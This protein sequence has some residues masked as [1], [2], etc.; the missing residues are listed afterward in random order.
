MDIDMALNKNDEKIIRAI[1]KEE[2]EPTK[3]CVQTLHQT[4]YGS[5]EKGGMKAVVARHDKDLDSLKTFRTQI[6]T[7]LLTIIPAIQFAI[8]VFVEWLR[9]KFTTG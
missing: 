9:S 6:K 8:A 3:E 1:F 4:V 2:L 5:D 7:A